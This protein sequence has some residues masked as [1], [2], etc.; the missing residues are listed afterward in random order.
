L[1]CVESGEETKALKIGHQANQRSIAEGAENTEDAKKVL[2]VS[3]SAV[4]SLVV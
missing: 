3:A 2:R 4:N 1:L